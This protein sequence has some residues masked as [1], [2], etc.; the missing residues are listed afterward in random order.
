MKN[1]V[2]GK[3]LIGLLVIIALA[4]IISH[5]ADKKGFISGVEETEYEVTPPTVEATA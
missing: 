4:V 2:F 5:F 1:T 3:L